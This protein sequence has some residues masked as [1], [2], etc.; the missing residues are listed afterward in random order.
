MSLVVDTRMVKLE[1]WVWGINGDWDWS[2][3][4][5]SC[6]QSIFV[7]LWDISESRDGCSNVSSVEFASLVLWIMMEELW[8][9]RVKENNQSKRHAIKSRSS[10]FTYVFM[11]NICVFYFVWPKILRPPCTYICIHWCNK[12]GWK[13]KIKK[14]IGTNYI[15]VIN[16][17]KFIE[18]SG[19]FFCK[20][21]AI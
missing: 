11:V 3:S 2:N 7:S 9:R 15:C 17:N 13:E 1:R 5:D 16:N 12:K 19:L 4:C 14:S 10:I 20:R 18:E 21:K 6:L 8:M